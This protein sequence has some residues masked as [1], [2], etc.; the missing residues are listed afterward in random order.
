MKKLNV[1]GVETGSCFE[2]RYCAVLELPLAFVV[3]G[4]GVFL[5]YSL[6]VTRSLFMNGLLVDSV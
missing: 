3:C 5:G 2:L 6:E 1:V 4:W